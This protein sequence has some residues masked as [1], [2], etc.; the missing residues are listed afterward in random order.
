VPNVLHLN[1]ILPHITT[2]LNKNVDIL[3][4]LSFAIEA[5]DGWNQL[6]LRDG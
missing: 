2:T 5:A 3:E 6:L 4:G 1:L